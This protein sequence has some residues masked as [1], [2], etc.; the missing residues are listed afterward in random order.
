MKSRTT[1]SRGYCGIGLHNP[2][3]PANVGSAL[4]AAQVYEAAFVIVQGRR[5]KP[6]STDTMKAYRHLPYTSAS[7][8]MEAIPYAC[9]PVAVEL[10]SASSSLF[11]YTHPERAI[12]IFGAE[13]AT[14]GNQ[15]LNRCRDIVQIPSIGCMNLAACVN[16]VL[17]DRAMKESLK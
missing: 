1:T 4:R 2:K 10:T 17:Y 3:T 16:V 12:Y 8:L 11:T 14:L 9:V 5:F 6:G 15:V 7:D 13:D